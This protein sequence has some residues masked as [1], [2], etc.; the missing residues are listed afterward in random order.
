MRVIRVAREEGDEG[1][2]VNEG[3]GIDEED[4]GAYSCASLIAFLRSFTT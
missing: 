4:A 2:E 1:D 3:D